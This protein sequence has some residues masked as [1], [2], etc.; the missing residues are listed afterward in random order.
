MEE[1][2]SGEPVEPRLS[3]GM[4][5]SPAVASGSTSSGLTA[6][7]KPGSD[8]ERHYP[9]DLLISGFDILFFWDAR[10][11]MQGIQFMKEVPWKRLYLHG[12]VRA[13]DGSK[14]SKSK[15]NVV[16]PLGL[17]DQYGADALR[18]FMAAMESQGRDIK[19]DDR[20]VEGYRNFATKLWNASRFCEAN[21]IG[22]SKTLAAPEATLPVNRWIISEVVET[23]QALDK[24]LADLRFDAAA[25]TIY[26]FTWDRFCD[27]Y[28]EL[29]KPVLSQDAVRPEPIEGQESSG[30]RTSISSARTEMD[31]TRTVAGWVLD[32]IIVML[33][34]FMPFITEELWHAMAI[35]NGERNYDLIVAKWPEPQAEVDAAAKAEIDWLIK[36]ISEVRSTKVEL[37]I[38][39]GTKMTAHV[40]DGDDALQAKVA[41][42]NAALDRVGR[43]E[44]ISF[45]AAPDGPSAQIVVDGATYV[46]PLAGAIDIDAEKGRLNKALEAAQK[47]AKSLS[48]R[49]GNANFVEKAK[50]EAVEKA[51]A[52]LAD[53]EAEAGRLQ[54]AIDR[55]G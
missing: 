19:M 29:I 38:A 15:G 14:M 18:F 41:R 12:L 46:L 5:R 4:R 51:R 37:N 36:L 25:N 2:V 10:M 31:E 3:D 23:Q 34:P 39:P 1:A 20:R 6:K 35:E 54:A 48:G 42:Q 26:H 11:A 33:H 21:G 43:L 13:E 27:W 30:N 50:P 45:D 9:N 24:A 8:L 44:A 22:A 53:K 7:P 28:L 49:L 32:Q 55:L 52:D 17:I 40:R 47:E 16:D